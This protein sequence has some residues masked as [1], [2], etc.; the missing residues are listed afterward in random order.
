MSIRRATHEDFSDILPIFR[1]V[2]EAGDTYDFEETV[3]DKE[4]FDYW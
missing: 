4:V 2:V 3:T 1:E